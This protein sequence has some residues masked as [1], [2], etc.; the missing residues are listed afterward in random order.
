[1]ANWGK[2]DFRQLEELQRKIEQAANADF[3]ALCIEISKDLA[4]IFLAK[5]KKRTLPGR[6]PE[7]KG[8][9][10]QEFQGE[11]QIVRKIKK[12]GNTY[13]VYY[14]KVKGKKYRFKT[15]EGEILEK[16]WKGYTGGTLRRGWTIGDITRKP[17]GYEVEIIN[18][19]EY[20]SYV[21]FGH[22]QRPGRYVPQI[23]KKLTSAWSPGKRMMTFTEQEIQSM[24]PAMIQ[25]K[26]EKFLREVM[27]GDQ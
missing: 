3:D 6:K 16:Y 8:P 26:F 25:K 12:K 9:L 2:T 17:N 22:R 7:F 1:M 27:S 21:E 20:A 14:T 5:V 23:G 4:K 18:P 13:S 11:D 24:A 19:V 15:K 10:T